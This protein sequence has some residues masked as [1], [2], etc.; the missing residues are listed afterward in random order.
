MAVFGTLNKFI[1]SI[2]VDHYHKTG[3][4]QHNIIKRAVVL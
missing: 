2:R 3:S 1:T 4:L